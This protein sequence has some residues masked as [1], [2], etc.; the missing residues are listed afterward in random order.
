MQFWLLNMLSALYLGQNSTVHGGTSLPA[1]RTA[2]PRLWVWLNYFVDQV[3]LCQ[4][5]QRL[6]SKIIFSNSETVW[7]IYEYLFIVS[8]YNL[9]DVFNT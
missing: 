7:G 8:S 4:H 6:V 9:F 3:G 1:Y 5:V 2:E